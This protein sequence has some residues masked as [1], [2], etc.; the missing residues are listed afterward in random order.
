MEHVFSQTA[1]RQ[2]SLKKNILTGPNVMHD[3][4]CFHSSVD[5]SFRGFHRSR[6]KSVHGF[7]DR[8]G[9]TRTCDNFSSVDLLFVLH[10]AL[11]EICSFEECWSQI[12]LK[13][14]AHK[15]LRVTLKPRF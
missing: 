7:L 4:E 10:F 14:A 6:T 15:A 1:I 5:V 12:E 9:E 11:Y 8:H 2:L 3:H 13:T